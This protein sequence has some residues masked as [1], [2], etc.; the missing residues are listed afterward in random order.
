MVISVLYRACLLWERGLDAATDWIGEH[1][2]LPS[3]AILAARKAAHWPHRLA[4]ASRSYRYACL[5]NA[6]DRF[7]ICVCPRPGAATARV[8][9][10]AFDPEHGHDAVVDVM[11]MPAP[12]WP[13]QAAR[14]VWRGIERGDIPV[15]GLSREDARWPRPPLVVDATPTDAG[16][17]E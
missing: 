8:R 12:W 6:R 15:R 9:L 14:A 1:V 2:G 4:S 5:V 17:E 7:V 3:A 16:R 11:F 10:F 13:A